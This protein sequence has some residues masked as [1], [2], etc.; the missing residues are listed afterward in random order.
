MRMASEEDGSSTEQIIH[1]THAVSIQPMPEFNP[2]AKVG[3][4]LAA[5]WKNWIEDFDVYSSYQDN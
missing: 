5:C 3:A 1:T 2:D 4:S